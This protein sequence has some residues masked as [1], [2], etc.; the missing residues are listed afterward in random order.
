M[1]PFERRFVRPSHFQVVDA[2]MQAAESAGT[3]LSVV[4]ESR[5]FLDSFVT[6]LHDQQ[7]GYH[8][9]KETDLPGNCPGIVAIAWWTD[10]LHR[11]HFRI[12]AGSSEDENH[13]SLLLDESDPR[14]PLW[15]LAPDQVFLR[16]RG[17]AEQWLAVC[18]CGMT[19]TPQSIGW[20][21]DRCGCCHYSRAE[22]P[23][24]APVR[25]ATFHAARQTLKHLA[26][27]PDRRWLAGA[28]ARA[29]VHLW[30]IADH[31]HYT[32]EPTIDAAILALAFTPDSRL[33][34]LARTDRLLHF[35]RVPFGEEVAA[36]P[37][38][39]AVSSI[40]IAPDNL[41]LVIVA[42]RSL[43][44]WGRPDV[45]LPWLPIY[46]REAKACSAAFNSRG[47][48][49]AVGFSTEVEVL[50]II[51]RGGCPHLCRSRW[52][53]RSPRPVAFS[54]DGKRVI[55]IQEET[56]Q[57][58]VCWE[59][60][61]NVDISTHSLHCPSEACAL[62]PDA[63]WLAGIQ[64]NGVDIAHVTDADRWFRLLSGHRAFTAL[65]FSPDGHTLAT[66]D[67]SGAVKLWPWRRLIEV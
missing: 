5:E 29:E 44:V 36:Y 38:P 22:A 40:V 25:F 57:K 51:E 12:W 41:T 31:A 53:T 10:H 46:V 33:L 62:S 39:H 32:F 58:V 21:G 63:N 37:T 30:D 49:L 3:D 52:M 65:A 20:M 55:F 14:P 8:Q 23:A 16:T 15:H 24:E 6:E 66:A 59:I 56:Q 35:Y 27:S 64:A 26:F 2:L 34:C 28:G 7:E 18:A 13:D 45:E 47:N 17:S 50:G 43:E 1:A 11:R 67:Q 19:G 42:D 60:D 54:G 48:R 4:E 9:W 61:R